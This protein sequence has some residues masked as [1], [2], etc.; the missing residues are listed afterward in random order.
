MFLFFLKKT[1]IIFWWFI[2]ITCGL[3][4][5]MQIDSLFI[6]LNGLNLVVNASANVIGFI[7][8]MPNYPDNI[9]EE[10]LIP[11]IGYILDFIY[12]ELIS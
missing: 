5:L 1:M 8:N 3:W 11:P 4:C 2:I 10:F 9:V 6:P 7:L 12:D